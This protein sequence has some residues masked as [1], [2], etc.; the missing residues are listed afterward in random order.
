MSDD[1][2]GDTVLYN[3]DDNSMLVYEYNGSSPRNYSNGL[4]SSKEGARDSGG[5][6]VPKAVL[7]PKK[8]PYDQD[9]INECLD[10]AE[11]RTEYHS[12]D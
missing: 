8:N 7:K 1:P 11:N 3:F 6:N 10:T 12:S 4:I 5:N 9:K 2:K